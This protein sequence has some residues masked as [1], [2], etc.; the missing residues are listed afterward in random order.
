[1][2]VVQACEPVPLQL[3]ICVARPVLEYGL[4]S[5]TLADAP[6]NRPKPPRSWVGRSLSKV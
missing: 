2:G 6:W 4:D 5:Q 3:K 1:M